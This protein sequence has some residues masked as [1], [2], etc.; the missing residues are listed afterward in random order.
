MLEND[1]NLIFWRNNDLASFKAIYFEMIS[2]E[3]LVFLL[4]NHIFE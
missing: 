3:I 2:I 1:P 4:E